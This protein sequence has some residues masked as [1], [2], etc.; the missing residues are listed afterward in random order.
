MDEIIALLPRSASRST[1]G[2]KTG[3]TFEEIAGAR[4]SPVDELYTIGY[5]N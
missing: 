2:K 4:D 5:I 1:A 3:V